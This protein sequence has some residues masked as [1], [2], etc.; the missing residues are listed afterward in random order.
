M[1]VAPAVTKQRRSWGHLVALVAGAVCCV[2]V[3]LGA[4]APLTVKVQTRHGTVTWDC[5]SRVMAKHYTVAQMNKTVGDPRSMIA[6]EAISP[7]QAAA[8]DKSWL[9]A[10]CS[11]DLGGEWTAGAVFVGG[12]GLILIGVGL[13]RFRWWWLVVP[14]AIAVGLVAWGL[15]LLFADVFRLYAGWGLAGTG[16]R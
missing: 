2:T 13:V 5:G 3:A 8:I 7:G 10:S 12:A 4:I 11:E 16:R 14:V 15:P 1:A 6:N 9:E